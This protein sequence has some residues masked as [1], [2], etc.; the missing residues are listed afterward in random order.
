MLVYHPDSGCNRVIWIFD[1]RTNELVNKYLDRE[2]EHT[3][4]EV[5]N[6]IKR[7][8]LSF[9]EKSGI[10]WV[11][12]TKTENKLIG[13]VGLWRFEKEHNRAEIGY[14]LHPVYW[15]KGFMKEAIDRVALFAFGPLE[16]HS[17][18]ANINPG[19]ASS[20]N[21]LKKCG[22]KKEAYFRENYFYKGKYLDSVIYSLLKKD[23]P[24]C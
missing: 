23:I 6:H 16:F 14:V 11:L 1:I 17:I 24:D 18:E 4:D 21:V 7:V 3:L 12:Y 5:L 19:N 13:Y 9:D 2:P 8:Q 22:F 20:E 15:G 10:N